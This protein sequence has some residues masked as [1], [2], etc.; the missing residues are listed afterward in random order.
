MKHQLSNL[1]F[2]W[3]ALLALLAASCGP[4]THVEYPHTPTEIADHPEI[5]Y[6]N[7]VK[8][9]EMTLKGVKLDD[10][11]FSIR[12]ERVLQQ[13]EGGWIVCRD[14]ARYR[15]ENH[16]IATL[17]VWDD[18]IIEQLHISS[19]EDIEKKFGK[20]QSTDDTPELLIYRYDNGSKTVLW[21][22]QENQVNAVNVSK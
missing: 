5:L 13:S 21:N 1:K 2:G 8:R 18:R 22:K 10:P 15:A 7:T 11:G 4:I 6:N 14:G 20:P 16:Q 19:P 9:T 3:L 12:P 17:G